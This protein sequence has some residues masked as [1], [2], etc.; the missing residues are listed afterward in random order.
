MLVVETA[1]AERVGGDVNQDRADI[2]PGD[3]GG[4]KTQVMLEEAYKTTLWNE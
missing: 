2:F 3:E 4:L 1:N